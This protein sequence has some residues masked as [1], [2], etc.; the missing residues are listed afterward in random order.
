[1]TSGTLTLRPAS[2]AYAIKG[3]INVLLFRPL[4]KEKGGDKSERLLRPLPKE[5]GGD[6][7]ERMNKQPLRNS[8]IGTTF[9]TIRANGE[10]GECE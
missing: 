4:P 3:K 6:K 8:S 10:K 2:T 5:K 7:S 1:M 9:F